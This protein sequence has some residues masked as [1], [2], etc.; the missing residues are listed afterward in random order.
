M[1]NDTAVFIP[2]YQ[3]IIAA[4]GPDALRTAL[5]AE[6]RTWLLPVTPFAHQ[7]RSKGVGVDCIGVPTE[8]GRVFDIPECE[9]VPYAYT[10]QPN[11]R[12]MQRE[13]EGRLDY[14][15]FRDVKVADMLWTRAYLGGP[16]QH[17][18]M[19]VG[20]GP[21]TILHASVRATRLTP[22]GRG[23]VVEHSV[24]HVFLTT[25]L[26]ACFRYRCLNG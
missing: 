24:D 4:E 5:V 11:E 23:Q 22:R 9:G 16:A 1:P 26:R 2:R 14:V 6:A 8:V 25:R 18:A 20:F 7:Q 13:L 19:I 17:L 12:E 15:P 3:Q 10:R 21:L